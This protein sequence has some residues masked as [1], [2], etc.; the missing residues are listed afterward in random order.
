LKNYVISHDRIWLSNAAPVLGML[1]YYAAYK[2]D[3]SPKWQI[4]FIVSAVILPQFHM[5]APVLWIGAV[6]LILLKK[7]RKI[8]IATVLYALLICIVIY[9]PYIYHEIL[10]NFS[11]TIAI[12]NKGGGRE[13][14]ANLF[15]IPLKVFGNGILFSSSEIGYH[16][17]RGYWGG[18]NYGEYYFSVKGLNRFFMN[19]GPLLSLITIFTVLLSTM[20]WVTTLGSMT[21]SFIKAIK[22]RDIRSVSSEHKVTLSFLVSLTAGAFLLIIAKKPYYP[23][24]INL[25]MP[26]LIIPV[27]LFLDTITKK[28]KE[29]EGY[30]AVTAIVVIIMIS[31]ASNSMRYYLNIDAL[32]G[33]DNTIEMTEK[34]LKEKSRISLKFRHFNNSSSWRALARSY[35]NKP[36][37]L[38]RNAKVKYIINNDKRRQKSKNRFY[39]GGIVVEKNSN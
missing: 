2:W 17:S 7:N 38:D 1:T 6:A 36:L 26:L 22:S 25:L 28:L 30:I 29:K 19:N 33:L 13:S 39:F 34:A 32:N 27:A 9:S 8:S 20:S 15:W 23:H 24:Y 21:S 14:A 5:S 37:K 31:M 3:S 4:L 18:F 16:F 12:L 10:H 35:F 11:N